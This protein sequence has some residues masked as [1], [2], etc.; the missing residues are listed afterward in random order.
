MRTGLLSGLALG[1]PWHQGCVNLLC[2][3]QLRPRLPL[4]QPSPS[5]AAGSEHFLKII[6]MITVCPRFLEL[7]EQRAICMKASEGL[8][9]SS[10]VY[11]FPF[12]RYLFLNICLMYDT[13]CSVGGHRLPFSAVYLKSY[14][15]RT[16]S[17]WVK[18]L[19]SSS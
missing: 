18:S 5:K 19:Q 4:G 11:S 15:Q 3:F 14:L 7:R 8:E 12:N 1:C 13:H 17:F 16:N 6:E 2:S 10:V 9:F